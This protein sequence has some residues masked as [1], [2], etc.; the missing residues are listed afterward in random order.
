VRRLLIPLAGLLLVAGCADQ[1]SVPSAQPPGQSPDPTPAATSEPTPGLATDVPTP[2]AGGTPQRPVALSPTEAL[3]DWR[4]VPGPT[5]ATV[6]TNG[7]WT[8]SLDERSGKAELSGPASTATPPG[9]RGR[10]SD[11]LLSEDWALVVHQDPREQ[12]PA[13]AVATNLADGTT[14]ILDADTPGAPT[15][16]GGTWA[17]DGDRAA[18]ATTGPDGAYCLAN[19]DLSTGQ[20]SVLWC[21][22]ARS[23]FNA[24]HLG[25]AGDAL[26]SFDDRQPSCRTVVSVSAAG[27]VPFEGVE[28]CKGF[29]GAVTQDGAIWSVVAKENRIEAAQFY[30]RTPQGYFDLGAGTSGT[31]TPCGAATYFVQD[32][33]GDDD[34]ARLL[35]WADG[36]LSTA[37]ASKAG[38]SFL[39]EPRCAGGV[40]SV[41]SFS[42]QGD[43]QVSAV[44]G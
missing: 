18:Y 1:D 16:S 27:T 7:T 12:D 2:P 23:G 32:P 33:Q 30:A 40:L 26:L 13:T 44:V 25:A 4:P 41:S 11:A 3:L 6:T 22:P 8:L 38:R 28:A 35:R 39:A 24:V 37:Y 14:T 31:L 36:V 9:V 43:E 5:S 15:R 10:V 42:E 20:A 21:A 19:A 17:L 34:P 29:E